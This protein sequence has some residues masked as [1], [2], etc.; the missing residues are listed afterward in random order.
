MVLY[1]GSTYCLHHLKVVRSVLC[2][3]VNLSTYFYVR[4]TIFLGRL[5][6]FQVLLIY[7]QT[8]LIFNVVESNLFRVV[9]IDFIC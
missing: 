6:V 9:L 1:D 5:N 3:F 8:L 2:V 4:S 7:F